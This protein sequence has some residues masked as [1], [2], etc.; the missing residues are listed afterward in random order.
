MSAMQTG[1]AIR[2]FPSM[3]RRLF[4]LSER[5]HPVLHIRLFQLD[6]VIAK[7]RLH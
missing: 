7:E 2:R 4:H 5:F 6:E 3:A 1:F